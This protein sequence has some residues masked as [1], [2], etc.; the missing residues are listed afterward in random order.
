MSGNGGKA[1]AHIPDHVMARASTAHALSS[2]NGDT[3][4]EILLLSLMAIRIDMW[5]AP[6]LPNDFYHLGVKR[7]LGADHLRVLAQ[8]V[9]L[10]V[11]ATWDVHA[12]ES[13]VHR[14]TPLTNDFG[15]REQPL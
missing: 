13:D 6:L 8:P 4:V 11:E 14:R 2:G 15:E 5:F 3:N 1:S 7:P 12:L 9:R 10:H